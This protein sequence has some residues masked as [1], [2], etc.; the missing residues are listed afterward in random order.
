[1]AEH[2]AFAGQ[3]ARRE[4][5]GDDAVARQRLGFLENLLG[6]DVE[7]DLALGLPDAGGQV[8]GFLYALITAFVFLWLWPH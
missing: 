1:M 4:Q 8:L 2:G 3:L 5:G 7:R 6:H